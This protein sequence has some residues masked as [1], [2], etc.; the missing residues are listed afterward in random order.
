MGRPWSRYIIIVSNYALFSMGLKKISVKL[1]EMSL[2]EKKK[3]IPSPL[4]AVQGSSR[5]LADIC[6]TG[7]C[8]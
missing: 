8:L 5:S 1:L 4:N 6:F 7:E 2:E 3:I